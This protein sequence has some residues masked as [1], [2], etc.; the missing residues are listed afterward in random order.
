MKNQD[1]F[2][3]IHYVMKELPERIT[4]AQEKLI[5]LVD[6]RKLRRWCQEN[7]ITHS[8]AYRLALGEILPN[9]RIMASMCHLIAPIDWLFFTD[10]TRPYE[11]QL[12]PKWDNAEPAKFIQEHRDD[13]RE[14]AKRYGLS[15]LIAYNIFVA[16]RKVP[17]VRLMR[18]A[19]AEVNPIEFFM[20]SSMEITPGYIPRKGDIVRTGKDGSTYLVITAS[21]KNKEF[22]SFTGCLISRS[23]ESGIELSGTRTQGFVNPRSLATVRLDAP[24]P[25]VLIEKTEAELVEKTASM[26]MEYLS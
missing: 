6:A 15:E 14:I 1:F 25:L 4:Y 16:H 19:C 9:Y 12:L 10:E 11:E 13:Y 2:G 22:N 17:T 18:D 7:G 8:A 21:E 20:P 26:A 5:K 23:C 24:A 3:I